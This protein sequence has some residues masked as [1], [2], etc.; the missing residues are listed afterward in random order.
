MAVGAEVELLGAGDQVDQG[1]VVARLADA[2]L[3]VLG[4]GA[5]DDHPLRAA[6]D[7]AH[8]GRV[9]GDGLAAARGAG[10]QRDVGAIG[11]VEE[12]DPLEGAAG[13]RVADGTPPR[14]LAEVES[15]GTK[16]AMLREA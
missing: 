11:G 7:R 1:L 4:G 5:V 10:D 2:G 8:Q 14:E 13:D 12:V 6:G 3:R 16:S 15:S 9:D